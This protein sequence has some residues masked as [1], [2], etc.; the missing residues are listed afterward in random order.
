MIILEDVLCAVVEFDCII[1]RGVS[2]MW[3]TL[4]SIN[5]EGKIIEIPVN[6]MQ[7]T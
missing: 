2:V 1:H 7:Y 5:G 6:T 3:S 4:I